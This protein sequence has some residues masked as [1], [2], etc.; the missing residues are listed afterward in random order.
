MAISHHRIGC[1]PKQPVP[2]STRETCYDLAAAIDSHVDYV[3][4]VAGAPTTHLA[5]TVRALRPDRF[6]WAV[7]EKV[8]AETAVGLSATGR[9]TCL[10]IKHNGLGLALDPLVNAA[11]HTIAAG[12]IIVSGDDPDAISSTV[13]QDSRMLGRAACA[14]TFEPALDGDTGLLM[15][16]AVTVSELARIPTLIKVTTRIHAACPT[17]ARRQAGSLRHRANRA[18]PRI[19]LDTA[20][21]LTKLGRHQRYRLVAAPVA[22][23]ALDCPAIATSDCTKPCGPA[24]IAVGATADVVPVSSDYCRLVVRAG[25]PAPATVVRFAD[26]HARTIVVEEPLPLLEEWLRTRIE[27]RDQLLGRLSG[28]LPPEGSVTSHDIARVVGDPQRGTWRTIARKSPRIAEPGRW[29]DLFT[30][31]SRL[32][33]EGVFVATDVGSSVQLCY[34]PHEGAD[35]ALCLGSPIAVAGGAARTGRTA[36]AVIGDYSLLHSGLESLFAAV[37]HKLP[38]TVVILANGMQAKTGGQPLPGADIPKLIEACGV[39]VVERWSLADVDA[40]ATHRRLVG[41]LARGSLT[42]LHVSESDSD[43]SGR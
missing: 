43:R 10:V 36:I 11:V 31:I 29:K 9:I 2:P 26:R 27:R 22:Q 33:R 23:A 41:L 1:T 35:V 34:P 21:R 5:E 42:V 12:I 7:N 16:I 3:L 17:D 32:R 40:A 39:D 30:A 19:D 28:H 13:V 8:A 25:P 18:T 14:P 15:D 24:V 38:M 6:E 20:H 4:A 37:E